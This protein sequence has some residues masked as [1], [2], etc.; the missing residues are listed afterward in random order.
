[1]LLQQAITRQ[2]YAANIRFQDPVVRL[3]GRDAYIAN[4]QLLNMLFDISF[5]VLSLKTSEPDHV[6]VKCA[7]AT[8]RPCGICCAWRP[9]AYFPT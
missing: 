5:E 8:L 3:R 9:A 7:L 2:R 4:V 1:V 6:D